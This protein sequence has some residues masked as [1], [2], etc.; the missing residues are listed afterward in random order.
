MRRCI[1]WIA[2][3]AS[4]PAFAQYYEPLQFRAN[5]PFVFCHYG[6]EPLPI[7]AC[8]IPISPYTGEFVL[9]GMC[10][11]PNTYGR[12]W[13]ARDTQALQQ[14][15]TACPAAV[16]SGEWSGSGDPQTTPFQH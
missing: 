8:W 7:N 12:P 13:T 9:T 5:D 16:N 3:S 11:P 15:V 10:D 6:Y 1:G 14:Y 2:L 4:L